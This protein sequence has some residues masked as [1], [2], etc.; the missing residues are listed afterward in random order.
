MVSF[1]N[2]YALMSKNYLNYK[3]SKTFRDVVQ[4]LCAFFL[5]DY[6]FR[7]LENSL[8]WFSINTETF[9]IGSY[10]VSNSYKFKF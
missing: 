7:L 3:K 1:I 10:H 6:S 5:N 8:F 2:K 4:S 9:H